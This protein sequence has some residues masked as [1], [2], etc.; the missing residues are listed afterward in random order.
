MALSISLAETSVGIPLADTYARITFM[1]CDKDQ[2]LLQITHYA[3]ADARKANATP[4]YD[5]TFFAPT[6]ELR[7][8]STPLEIGYAWLKTQVEYINAVDC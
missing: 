8:G 5:R 4:I 2:T 3:N 6:V 1:R 7:S